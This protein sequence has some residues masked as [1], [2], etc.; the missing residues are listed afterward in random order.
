MVSRHQTTPFD[1]ELVMCEPQILGLRAGT[2]LPLFGIFGLRADS[3]IQTLG[4]GGLGKNQTSFG[5]VPSFRHL[6]DQ[7]FGRE[8]ANFFLLLLHF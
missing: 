4:S 2:S 5:R 8:G 6:D 1:T 3:G 7:F